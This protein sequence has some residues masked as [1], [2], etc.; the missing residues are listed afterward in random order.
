[1][2]G[3][4]VVDLVLLL[5]LVGYAVGMYRTGLVAGALSLAGLLGGGLLALWLLPG[6][7]QQWSATDG[8]PALT[9][10]ALIA[11]IL[12]AAVLGQAIGARI[13]AR[14][15]SWVR[16]RPA[17]TV[18]S[19]LGAA[20]ALVV[21]ATLVWF[22]A[23]AVHGA[24]PTAATQAVT[25]SR[26]LQTIDRAMPAA[27][28]RVLADARQTL[29]ERDFPRVFS[30]LAPEPIRPVEPP[31]AGVARGQG[32]DS[33]ADSV[34]RVT[35]TAHECGRGKEGSGWVAA[36]GRVVTNAHVVA[37]VDDPSVQVG[38]TGREYPATTVAFDPQRDVAVL[39]VPDLETEPLPTG[40]QLS[41]GDNVVA[42]GFPRG[43]PYELEEGRVRDV[44]DARGAGIYGNPGVER[45]VYSVSGELEPGNSGGPLLSP[46][47][48]VVGTVFATSMTDESTGYALTLA[49]TRPVV[50]EAAGATEPVSTGGCTA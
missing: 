8:R 40:G 17:R 44:I 50:Q 15:R 18:D 5:V 7:L 38:G 36:P 48:Q 9:G 42:A 13:G 21:A 31:E 37:G 39:A 16:W 11:G 1:M 45:E 19:V 49:E 35:G 47:G 10:L 43:G 46:T 32:V 4:I 41:H 24:L 23:G 22:A 12:L 2:T 3:G 20:G 27:A 25:N 26:V 29:D 6:L 14:L 33:A 34:V 30:G 28:D